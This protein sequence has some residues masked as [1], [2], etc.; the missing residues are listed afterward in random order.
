MDRA[1]QIHQENQR[2]DQV[3]DG[4]TVWDHVL[5]ED[6]T[7]FSRGVDESQKRSGGKER[8][9]PFPSESNE[10]EYQFDCKN[11]ENDR[12]A[13]PLCEAADAKEFDQRNKN[14]LSAEWQDMTE[15]KFGIAKV[16]AIPERLSPE[17]HFNIIG[18][19]LLNEVSAHEVIA[20][21]SDTE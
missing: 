9:F 16:A 20:K 18:I 17:S 4:K 14:Q 6:L 15:R 8:A 2:R 12:H 7:G 13:K 11:G 5:P 1:E 21:R 3:E 10:K 19:C